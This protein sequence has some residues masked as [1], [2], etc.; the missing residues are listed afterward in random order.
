MTNH[1]PHIF[2]AYARKD[3]TALA[4]LKTHL[5]I[6]QRRNLCRIFYDGE[7]APGEHWDKRLKD[8]LHRAD[9]FVLL[10]SEEFLDS[11]YI[12]EVEL[13]KILEKEKN[14]KCQVIPVILRDCLWTYTELG[15]AASRIG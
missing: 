9:I 11:D 12:H 2:I 1:I 3:K 4:K 10:V 6:L 13:P 7:I 5:N 14:N 15:R 8:E